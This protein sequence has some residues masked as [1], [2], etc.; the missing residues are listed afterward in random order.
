MKT[1]S[2]AAFVAA[3]VVASLS[4]QPL[5]QGQGGAPDIPSPWPIPA[6]GETSVPYNYCTSSVT[7]HGCVASIAGIG[8]PSASRDDGFVLAVS[9]VEGQQSGLIFYGCAGRVANPWTG[10][11][12]FM[13]VKSPL[14]RTP[15]QNSGGT[16]GACD[17]QLSL[18][19]NYYVASH[20]LAVGCPF[21]GGEMV[22]AQGWFRVPGEP[23]TYLSD[24]LAF[25]VNP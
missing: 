15:V 1:T 20:P 21:V 11:K 3:V 7:S 23:F 25:V 22:Y 6:P 18:D 13:C 10:S 19:W 4:F 16:L 24:A 5:S 12:S 14:E 17:G 2:I 8:R 9:R